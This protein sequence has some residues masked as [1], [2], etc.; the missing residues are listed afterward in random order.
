[1]PGNLDDISFALGEIKADIRELKRRAEE[2]RELVTIR[3]DENSRAIGDA[4]KEIRDFDTRCMRCLSQ[5]PSMAAL[6]QSRS[7]LALW[8]SIGIGAFVLFG[9]IVEATI[10]WAVTWAWS[11]LH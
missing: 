4:V 10:K 3:H 7:R 11:H 2:D 6:E 9:W 8:A 5:R 1:M